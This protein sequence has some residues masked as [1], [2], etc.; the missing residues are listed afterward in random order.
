MPDVTARNPVAEY[1]ALLDRGSDD[2]RVVG[3]VVYGSRA[4]GPFAQDVSDVDVFVVV[5]GEPTDAEDWQ[6]AHGSP[7]ETWVISLDEFRR[8][9]LPGEPYAW[10]R[11]ALIRAR[12]DLDKLDGEIGRIV[13]RKRRLEP[14]EASALVD[15]AIDATFN[16][17]L[18]AV[19]NLESGRLLG[20]R[21]DALEALQPLL[22]VVFALESRVRPFNK[23]LVFEL[24]EEPLRTLAFGDLVDRLEGYLADPSTEHVRD[25][26]RMIEDAARAAG[27]G[28]IVDSWEPDL[29]WFR[30]E[31]AYRS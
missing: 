20:G 13:D 15:S 18:R 5:Q 21:M 4:A 12:V 8:H 11:P 2:E 30:G 6:T 9:A 26:F 10:N 7:V 1:G 3:L 29:A 28:A 22:T 25:A 27:H 17:M 24:A 19:R 31:A 23:W 14:D 16:S